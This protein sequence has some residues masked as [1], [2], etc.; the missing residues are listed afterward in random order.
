MRVPFG[1][2]GRSGLAVWQGKKEFGKKKKKK[3]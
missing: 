1:R 3:E 2:M